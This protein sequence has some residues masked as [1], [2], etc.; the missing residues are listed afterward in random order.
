MIKI[1][2]MTFTKH[3]DP[4][5]GWLAVKRSLLEQLGLLDQISPYSYQKGKTVY[6]EEDGD[7]TKFLNILEAKGFTFSFK[8]SHTNNRSPIRGYQ[9]F[10]RT[11]GTTAGV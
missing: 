5:H 1:K 11:N 8:E 10:V 7:M 9:N 4:S 2:H 6:L 3:N